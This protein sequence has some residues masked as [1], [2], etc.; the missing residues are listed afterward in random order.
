MESRLHSLNKTLRDN[1][2]PLSELLKHSHTPW[3]TDP[4]LHKNWF[5][6]LAEAPT[7]AVHRPRHVSPGAIQSIHIPEGTDTQGYGT[8]WTWHFRQGLYR[9]IIWNVLSSSGSIVLQGLRYRP[10]CVQESLVVS[11]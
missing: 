7:A 6:S 2:S 9:T 4:L 1:G 5:H 10:V 3:L 8:S 11:L